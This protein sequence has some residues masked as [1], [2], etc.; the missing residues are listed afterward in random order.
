MSRFWRRYLSERMAPG[1]KMAIVFRSYAK[2]I[3]DVEEVA[4]SAIKSIKTALALKLNGEYVFGKVVVLVPMD[5]DC[6]GTAGKIRYLLTEENFPDEFNVSERLEILQTTGHHSCDV[7][8]KTLILLY[9]QGMERMAIVSN[10]AIAYVNETT[11]SNVSRAFAEGYFKAVGVRIEE[12]SEVSPIPFN[13][14]FLVWDVEELL[15]IGGFVSEN[16]VEE[17]QPLIRIIDR[18]PFFNCPVGVCPGKGEL[19]IRPSDSAKERYSHVMNTKAE[20]QEREIKEAGKEVSWM[21]ARTAQ[22]F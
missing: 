7:L 19:K 22:F 21:L 8:N 6:G 11:M 5:Y 1:S 18:H 10:K 14:I 15:R 17:I 2:N 9:Q 13:N 16:G 3:G 12:L 20:R 4:Q